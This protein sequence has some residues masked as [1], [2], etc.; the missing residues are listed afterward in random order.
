MSAQ[1]HDAKEE[2]QQF[3]LIGAAGSIISPNKTAA[4]QRAGA[5]N[6][7]RDGSSAVAYSSYDHTAH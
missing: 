7:P 3:Y 6:F 1:S 2:K 5:F 4:N